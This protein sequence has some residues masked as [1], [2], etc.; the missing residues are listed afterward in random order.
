MNFFFKKWFVFLVFILPLSGFAQASPEQHKEGIIY[1]MD[2]AGTPEF[3]AD[4]Q[5]VNLLH[6]SDYFKLLSGNLKESFTKPFH[7]T[8]KDWGNFGKFTLLAVGVGFADKP[9]QKEGLKFS[10]K[11]T[12]LNK[13][14]STLSNIAGSSGTIIGLVATGTVGLIIKDRKL[15][16]TTL[17][18]TQATITGSAITTSIK[19]L[20]GRRRP[21]SF[22]P[23]EEARPTFEGPFSKTPDGKSFNHSFPSGHATA[24]FAIVTVFASEY[25]D[26]PIVPILAYGLATLVGISRITENKHWSTDVLTGAAIG[27]LSGKQAVNNFHKLSKKRADG[28]IKNTLLFNL[29][30]YGGHW[31][32]GMVLHLN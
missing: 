14:S 12:S 17:L 28:K 4:D 5:N 32:P 1:K 22:L 13:I 6:A 27:Y 10:Q 24:S 29:N 30:Y 23:S 8:K 9:I 18:A 26:K 19:F 15:V 3:P 7:A 11:S 2:T 20:A 21:Y 25:R 16:N 31:E